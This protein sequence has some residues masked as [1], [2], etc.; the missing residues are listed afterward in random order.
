MARA[1]QLASGALLKEGFLTPASNSPLIPVTLYPPLA[2]SPS[3]ILVC[4]HFRNVSSPLEGRGAHVW[5][6]V[7]TQ[8]LSGGTAKRIQHL[9][10]A[11]LSLLLQVHK[12]PPGQWHP[13]LFRDAGGPL[14]GPTS[15]PSS[16]SARL[17]K[18]LA[19]QC[20]QKGEEQV[21]DRLLMVEVIDVGG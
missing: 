8:Q 2:L 12:G 16:R 7:R 4:V 10:R 19:G 18:P 5:P 9:F 1:P 15:P 21:W 17:P 14:P 13:R 20:A 11:A 6:R 3:S